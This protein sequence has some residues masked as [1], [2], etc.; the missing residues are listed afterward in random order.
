M[1]C[2]V[3]ELWS[4]TRGWEMFGRRRRRRKAEGEQAQARMVMAAMMFGSAPPNSRDLEELRNIALR[5]PLDLGGTS[6]PAR[7]VG[8][9]SALDG[10][11]VTH[12]DVRDLAAGSSARPPLGS[13]GSP[14]AP[15]A[16]PASPSEVAAISRGE[17][18]HARF[19][20]THDQRYLDEAVAVFES[21]LDS[22]PVAELRAAAL[23][24]LGK[25]HWSRFEALSTR[26]D[27]D[28]AVVR[29]REALGVIPE[30]HRMVPALRAN[31]AGAL[32]TRWGTTARPEDL[33]ES[34]D[35]IRE[36]LRAT[37]VD[38]PMR[39]S[40]LN[41]LGIALLKK[42]NSLGDSSALNEC[43]ATLR[44]ALDE[45]RATAEP[46]QVTA[47]VSNLSEALRLRHSMTEGGDLEALASAAGLARQAVAATPTSD[48][49]WARFQSNLSIVLTN[50]YL[51]RSESA[52]LAEAVAAS[53]RA[54]AAT[55]ERHP[56]RVERLVAHAWLARLQFERSAGLAHLTGWRPASRPPPGLPEP[57]S[58]RGRELLRAAVRAAEDALAA[59]PPGHPSHTGNRLFLVSVRSLRDLTSGDARPRDDRETA[60]ELSAI[61]RDAGQPT[62]ERLWAARQWAANRLRAAST[63]TGAASFRAGEEALTAFDLATE[64]LP[65]TAARSLPQ[66]DRERL[67]A[68]F[69]GLA[70]DAAAVALRAPEPAPERALRMLENGRGVLLG[71][72]IDARDDVH[73]LRSRDPRLADRYLELSR[74]LDRPEAGGF[75]SAPVLPG[76]AGFPS[77]GSAPDGAPLSGQDRHA[78]AAAWDALVETVRATPGFAGFLRPPT[79]R[80]L[81]RA[82]APHGPVVVLN[83]SPFGCDALLIEGG[84]VRSV[85]LPD[86]AYVD[87]LGRAGRFVELLG[88]AGDPALPLVE[89]AA[90]QRGIVET[91]GWLWTAVAEPVL[92]ALGRTA[93]P[94]EGQA[95]PRVWW[96][97]TGPLSLFPLHA[98]GLPDT[99]G[100]ST[101]DR[102]V[103]SYAT[104][105]RGLLRARARP[106][107]GRRSVLAVAL[108]GA[109]GVPDL[110]RVDLELARL[111]ERLP[112]A[113]TL[114][115]AA[116]R[117]ETVLEALPRHTWTHIA[118][119]AVSPADA[120]SGG[121]LLLY[122]HGKRPLSTGD[123]ARLRLERA[124]LAYLS[125]CDTVRGHEALAD[126]AL[127]IAG[128][129]HTAGFR[130][131]IG[132]LWPVDDEEAAEIADAFYARVAS[133]HALGDASGSARALHAAVRA[134]RAENPHT[135]TLWAAHLHYG[136]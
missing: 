32:T 67:L 22:R 93:P 136:A 70:R 38:D 8:I 9:N 121:Q 68:Q 39:V 18:L 100:A 129:F 43:V 16:G 50:L 76:M 101:L 111:A 55:P 63:L 41:H 102:V 71:Q 1:A 88:R 45:G 28:R 80:E 112:L 17:Q 108:R 125:A 97:P 34:I 35:E 133:G 7:L 40:R 56:N 83:T 27:I 66:S 24:G 79:P 128:A 47:A 75:L 51:A 25:C 29:L 26:D 99:P 135:P 30:G 33:D 13:G 124:E 64:L 59:T 74:A 61:A 52:D 91:L 84:R 48:P 46:A 106:V 119:H 65:R 60:R 95:P 117:Y 23:N 58:G 103:S 132:T 73:E 90:A 77:G 78:L 123:I 82:A 118:C 127:H 10:A 2:R 62:R 89:Q 6:D 126:E 98:A 37:A 94:V 122:D 14:R 57:L 86:V 4:G 107:V 109:A 54:L 19:D 131:V 96:I 120:T 87:L 114:T 113:R 92:T 42:V 134:R 110:P 85:P 116:A 12:L 44:R 53:R 15:S 130:H 31:L 11:P 69:V 49:L 81:A 36:A 3:E 105:V 5:R 21:L 115:G 72:A 104:T 20:A